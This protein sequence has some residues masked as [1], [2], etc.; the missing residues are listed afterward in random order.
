MDSEKTVTATFSTPPVSFYTVAPCRAYD[1]R[2]PAWASPLRAG[3]YTQL[4][5]GGRCGI[6]ATAKAVSLNVTVVSPS[7]GGHLRLYASGTPR[8]GTSSINY[9]SGQTRANNAVVSLGVAGAVVVY[10]SQPSGTAH[11]VLDVT[12]YFQ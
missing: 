5:M 2:S 1:S 7:A 9:V 4:A 6:P 11:V 12:G 8:P 3:T 10:V